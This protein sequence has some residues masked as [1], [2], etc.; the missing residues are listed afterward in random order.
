MVLAGAVVLSLKWGALWAWGPDLEAGGQLL[1]ILFLW[2][3]GI[4]K[5][6]EN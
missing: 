5:Y 6:G 4:Y 2:E 1:Y 3:T